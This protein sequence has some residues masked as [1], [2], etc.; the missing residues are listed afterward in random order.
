M[1]INIKKKNLEF[2]NSFFLMLSSKNIIN[3]TFIDYELESFTKKMYNEKHHIWSW[4]Q[5]FILYSTIA[6]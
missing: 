2:Q 1:A 3:F 5:L 4:G 6:K